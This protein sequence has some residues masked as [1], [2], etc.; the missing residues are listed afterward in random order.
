MKRFI[1][2]LCIFSF[3]NNSYAQLSQGDI[4]QNRIKS[5]TQKSWNN[6]LLYSGSEHKYNKEGKIEEDIYFNFNV[7]TNTNNF[8]KNRYLY[9]NNR[10]IRTF[11]YINEVLTDSTIHYVK[12]EGYNWTFTD[13]V[14]LI[15][16]GK[17]S[18]RQNSKIED[19]TGIHI[20]NKIFRNDSIESEEIRFDY[21]INDSTQI[22][23][24]KAYSY[25]NGKKR[26]Y[27]NDS[28][29]QINSSRHSKSVT[30]EDGK[31]LRS[32]INEFKDSICRY[33]KQEEYDFS[34]RH[35]IIHETWYD[36]KENPV[37]KI[38]T[39]KGKSKFHYTTETSHWKGMKT[40]EKITYEG[41]RKIKE[42]TR[43]EFDQRN[44]PQRVLYY[45]KNDDLTGKITWEYTYW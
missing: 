11:H 2:Q 1:F 36:E 14:Y 20:S 15:A 12:W 32:F 37:K 5:V 42:K 13:T 41:K 19:S 43:S 24:E 22:I 29:T 16:T 10:I 7:Q 35:K 39:G 18:I 9:K 26:I 3:A 30:F 28:T 38:K 23:L 6:G 8:S 31:F 34:G 21:W 45:D 27:Q 40:E 4:L 25:F 33:T 44:L 17:I